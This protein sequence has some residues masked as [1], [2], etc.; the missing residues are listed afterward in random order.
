L[1]N[2]ND[3]KLSSFLIELVGA[4]YMPILMYNDSRKQGNTPY[5]LNLIPLTIT[6]INNR[7]IIVRPDFQ[8]FIRYFD[9]FVNFVTQLVAINFDV[10]QQLGGKRKKSLKR[11][12]TRRVRKSRRHRK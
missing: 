11:R 12:R 5:Y 1:G 7:S 4:I 2:L 6:R 9:C 8:F 3:A 10:T